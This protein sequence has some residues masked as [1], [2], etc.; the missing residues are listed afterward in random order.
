MRT[1]VFLLFAFWFC[2]SA[3]LDDFLPAH[4]TGQIIHHFAYTMEFADTYKQ[5]VWV[6][7]MICRSRVEASEAPRTDDFRPDP[8]V[9]TKSATPRDYS[10]SGYDKGHL[11]PSAD[12][13]WNEQAQSESF[14]MSNMSPQTP[15][16]NRGIWKHLED[17]VREWGRDF[18]TLYIVTG[19]ILR[20]G[21]PTIGTSNVAVPEYY[22]K[23]VL[24][25]KSSVKEAVGFILKNEGSKDPLSEFAVSVDSIGKVT[26]IDFFPALPDSIK[27]RVVGQ[28]D[29][30]FWHLIS[31][32]ETGT[33]LSNQS[34]SKKPLPSGFKKI[35][36]TRHKCS[37][38]CPKED[39]IGAACGDGTTSSNTG[40]EACAGHG[41]VECW[42]CK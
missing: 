20:P 18:D 30:A 37:I 9:G 8:S 12:F 4:G 11:A 29:L 36:I 42:E 17:K 28:V 35:K 27:K 33:V 32:T 3:P 24:D 19:P 38:D 21:L 5:P 14:F 16:L 7:Y 34:I 41:G 26:G 39:R 2:Q 23:V 10:R 22:Y 6:C 31:E 13:R 40:K 15:A 25:Y 1:I